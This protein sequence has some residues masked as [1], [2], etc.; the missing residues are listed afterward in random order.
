MKV[1]VGGAHLAE[2]SSGPKHLANWQAH[3]SKGKPLAQQ[4]KAS[5]ESVISKS[6]V[7]VKMCYK[8]SS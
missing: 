6:G 3:S 8:M 2:H 7:K 5:S 4:L 1:S